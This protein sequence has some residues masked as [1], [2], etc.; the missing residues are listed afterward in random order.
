MK[1]LVADYADS[2]HTTGEISL[3]KATMKKISLSSC[4]IK[5]RNNICRRLV[6]EKVI[7]CLGENDLATTTL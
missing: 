3:Y 5:L 2:E 1:I 4:I 6:Y 7:D